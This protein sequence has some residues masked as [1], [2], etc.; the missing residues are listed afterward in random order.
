MGFLRNPY[1]TYAAYTSRLHFDC[2][3]HCFTAKLIQL[4]PL[5]ALLTLLMVCIFGQ[6]LSQI[7]TR[8]SEKECTFKTRKRRKACLYI[9]WTIGN[10]H[11]RIQYCF[12]QFLVFANF[13]C[14]LAQKYTNHKKN[15]VSRQGRR[16][17]T[18]IGRSSRYYTKYNIST[19]NFWHLLHNFHLFFALIVLCFARS[20][21]G[22]CLQPRR[23]NKAIAL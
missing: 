5:L 14:A 16:V 1:T 8:Q 2:G 19:L 7:Q 6:H 23:P 21:R 20:T 3:L 15:L 18:F 4:L 9:Y 10:I 12:P 17:C 13:F 22:Q 11:H